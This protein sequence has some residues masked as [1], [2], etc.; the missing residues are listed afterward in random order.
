M[1]CWVRLF[2]VLRGREGLPGKR[3]SRRDSGVDERKEMMSKRR[4]A[5]GLNEGF[6]MVVEGGDEQQ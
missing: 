4:N 2:C 5:S 6:A 3:G 1:D